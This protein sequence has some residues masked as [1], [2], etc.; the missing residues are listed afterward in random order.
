MLKLNDNVMMIVRKLIDLLFVL[1]LIVRNLLVRMRLMKVVVEEIMRVP[2]QRENVAFES[3][4]RRK[5]V[6]SIRDKKRISKVCLL[7]SL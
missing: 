2:F 1:I 6:E 4:E 5:Q 7:I 3:K